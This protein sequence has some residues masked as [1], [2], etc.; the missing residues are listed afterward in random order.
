M[1]GNSPVTNLTV[2]H[3]FNIR[4][5]TIKTEGGISKADDSLEIVIAQAFVSILGFTRVAGGKIPHSK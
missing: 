1:T 3:N 5:I 4:M 2:F